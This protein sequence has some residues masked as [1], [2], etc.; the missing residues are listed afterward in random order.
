[1]YKRL[2]YFRILE[3]EYDGDPAQ[4]VSLIILQVLK[5][6]EIEAYSFEEGEVTIK[7]TSI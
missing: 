3:I 7:P 2:S 5:G 4:N 6:N 1:M